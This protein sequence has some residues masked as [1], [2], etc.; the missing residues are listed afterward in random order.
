MSHWPEH[1]AAT[2]THA[3]RG[4]VSNA[5][6]YRI[7]YVLIDPEA[8]EGPW[9]F[10]RN[11]PNF[12]SVH[13]RDHGGPRRRGQGV[14]WVRDVL[15]RHGLEP[16]P[17]QRIL[18]LTQPRLF[19]Y[20]FNPVSFWLVLDGEV[21][22]AA[23]AEVNNTFGDRH[24]YL[25]RREGFRPIGSGDSIVAEKLF[26]VSPFQQVAGTYAFTFTVTRD[27]I[28]IRIAHEN[29]SEG[30]IATLRGERRPLSSTGLLAAFL[31][32]PMGAARTIALIYL[33]AL[34]LR[35]KGAR[36]RTRPLPPTE[37]IS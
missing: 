36:Y 28:A 20:V 33:Q 22:V 5:F 12:A 31:H 15:A 27:R 6:R 24:S 34:R 29:G 2:T 35:L 30:L 21:L 1:L 11:W 26:H 19:G 9:L 37:E 23:I 17:G 10:S 32:R 3:R 8:R 18:L 13:D 25:C 7:D 4:A 14:A 16:T